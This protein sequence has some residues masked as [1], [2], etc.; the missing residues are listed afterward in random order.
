MNKQTNS[1]NNIC[2]FSTSTMI[3]QMHCPIFCI[4]N[5]ED[6][7]LP[8]AKEQWFIPPFSIL[9][10]CLCSA[11]RLTLLKRRAVPAAM[12]IPRRSGLAWPALSHDHKGWGWGLCCSLTPSSLPGA[13]SL[14]GPVHGWLTLEEEEHTLTTLL[15]TFRMWNVNFHTQ[16]FKS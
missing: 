2:N 7:F 13:A 4:Q 8:L 3:P 12:C 9:S 10:S 6:S 5:M 11:V 1:W 14:P 15:R 16:T